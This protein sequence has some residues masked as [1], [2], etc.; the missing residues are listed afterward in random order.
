MI[1]RGELNAEKIKTNNGQEWRIDP[2]SINKQAGHETDNVRTLTTTLWRKRTTDRQQTDSMGGYLPET[3]GTVTDP[4]AD[5]YMARLEGYVARD[6]ELLIVRAVE[7]AQAPLMEEIRALRA[8]QAPLLKHNQQLLDRIKQLTLAHASLSG[9]M[10]A[11]AAA[12]TLLMDDLRESR[13]DRAMLRA[14]IARLTEVQQRPPE[15]A[16]AVIEDAVDTSLVPYL[17]QVQQVSTDVDRVKEEN[18]RLKAK[19]VKAEAETSRLKEMLPQTTP[20][21][22]WKLW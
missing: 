17:K 10:E 15:V 18:E 12:H 21:P 19:L 3:L 14:E 1:A 13:K 22:W 6:M 2:Q 8:E 5:T 16:Q 20:R 4:E 11:Q 7:A 9:Y